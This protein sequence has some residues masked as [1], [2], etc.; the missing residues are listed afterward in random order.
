[1]RPSTCDRGPWRSCIRERQQRAASYSYPTT[2]EAAVGPGGR[3]AWGRTRRQPPRPQPALTVP[4][5]VTRNRDRSR[6]CGRPRRAPSAGQTARELFHPPADVLTARCCSPQ[7]GRNAS[8]D[9]R[10]PHPKSAGRRQLRAPKRAPGAMRAVGLRHPRAAGSSVLQRQHPMAPRC[11]DR[12][13]L[14]PLLPHERRRLVGRLQPHTRQR[15]A[16][17]SDTGRRSLGGGATSAAA[18]GGGP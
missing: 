5:D 11:C 12:S 8:G 1:M 2:G 9:S 18:T 13:A 3:A 7:V 15:R 14:F 16:R 17:R 4:T 10:P 6:P